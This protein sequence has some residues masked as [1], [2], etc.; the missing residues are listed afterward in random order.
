VRSGLNGGALVALC[1]LLVGGCEAILGPP[2]DSG[3]SNQDLSF[4]VR[5]LDDTIGIWLGGEHFTAGLVAVTI[6]PRAE[7][8]QPRG[9]TVM[10]D[11]SNAMEVTGAVAE[12]KTN[13]VWIADSI[14]HDRSLPDCG[15][16]G[17]LLRGGSYESV[18]LVMLEG[19]VRLRLYYKLE[20]MGSERSLVS[21][22]IEMPE[23][24]R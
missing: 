7:M 11:T 1:A 3:G 15:T 18:A 20:Q 22:E 6:K 2:R 21:G 19:R 24:A 12:R 13:G 5:A 17:G 16:D 10:T 23:R 14:V 4:E 9:C 8:V